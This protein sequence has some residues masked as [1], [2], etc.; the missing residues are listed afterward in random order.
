M[1]F[2][3]D[4]VKTRWISPL[5]PMILAATPRGIAGLWFEGQRHMPDHGSWPED[6]GHPLLREAITQLQAYFAGERDGFALP[7]DLQ[8]GTPFQQSVWQALLAIPC[9]RTT[10]YSTLSREIGMPAAARAVG[11]AVGRN[12]ISIMVPCHRVMGAG[13]ALTGYA[14]GL[15]RKSAL[16]KLERAP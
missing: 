7:L 15:E 13:G 2:H 11:A 1:K 8:G 4:I 3:P 14:G 16:L 10:S 12:P 9:G 5:G 6:A